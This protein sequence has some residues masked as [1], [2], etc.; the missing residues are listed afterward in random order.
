ME[1]KTK[2]K[3]ISVF[4]HL[5]QL[6]TKCTHN[7]CHKYI[8]ISDKGDGIYSKSMLCL[9]CSRRFLYYFEC[10]SFFFLLE[11][12]ELCFLFLFFFSAASKW[13]CQTSRTFGDS[14]ERREEKKE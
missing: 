9:F 8:Y 10:S 6:R 4:F 7:A 11:L 1:E 5:K 2:N 12:L 3:E 13:I 14:S